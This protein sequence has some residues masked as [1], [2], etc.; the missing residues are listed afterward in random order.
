VQL[1]H[2]GIAVVDV[3][4][5]TAEYIDRFSFEPVGGLVHDPTQTAYA[6]FLRPPGGTTFVELIAP[7]GPES[8]LAGALKRGGGLHHLCYTSDD[9][10]RACAHLR[11]CNMVLVQAPVAAVAFP[12]RRIAWLV[13]R[14]Q[15]LIELLEAG[16]PGQL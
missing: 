6:R 1:H 8:R 16:P 11:D 15:I 2:I 7:D 14:D 10:E 13:G 12:G 5:A 9:I 4:A 3:A